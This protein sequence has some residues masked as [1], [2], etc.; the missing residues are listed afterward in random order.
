MHTSLPRFLWLLIALGTMTV[1]E[2]RTTG[3]VIVANRNVPDS[4]ELAG[5]Y[6]KQRNI[7]SDL[8]CILDLPKGEAM[9][10]RDYET[11]LRDPLLEFLRQKELIRQ[12]PRNPEE[13]QPNET[14]WI[15]TE[16]SVDYIVSIYGVPVRI[17]DTRGRFARV[18]TDG[19]ERAQRRD[20]ASVDSELALLLAPGYD[21]KGPLRNPMFGSLT[22]TRKVTDEYHL[23][24]AARLDGPDADTARRMLDDALTAERQGLLGRVYLDLR[25]L[26]DGPYI[27]GDYWIREAGERLRREGYEI[28]LDMEEPIWETDFPMEHAAVYLGWYAEELNGPFTRKDFRFQ[29][30]A[31]AYHLHSASAAEL[32][33]DSKFWAGPLLARGAAATMGAVHEPFLSFSPDL[34]L[35]TERLC[36]G[37]SFG[38]SA[39]MAMSALSWQI[40][41][42]GDPLYRPFRL[43]LQVQIRNLEGADNQRLDWASVRMINLLVR[44]GRFNLALKLGRAILRERQSLILQEKLADLYTLN[45]L[46]NEA[47]QIYE[48]IIEMADTPETAL[49][50][51]ARWIRIL[52]LLKQ[53]ERAKK[54]EDDLRKRYRRNPMLGWIDRIP[55]S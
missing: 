40:T 36:M 41:V 29:P 46:Y 2:A 4:I 34:K 52:R 20:G 7:P 19:S 54:I 26:R 8:V 10:R 3:V 21:I 22:P 27:L 35:F 55:E 51:G 47:G 45:E 12:S 44:E 28:A 32:R 39:Y 33:T 23:V 31:I 53:D 43:P 42:V 13:V 16:S 37:Y 38:E 15:T 25:G 24:V 30:G 5:Y 17:N 50:V 18:I 49:R 6:A 48:N 1:A 14:P 11:K 9:S